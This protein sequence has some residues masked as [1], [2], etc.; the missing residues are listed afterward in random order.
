MSSL[1]KTIMKSRLPPMAPNSRFGK[2][3][4]MRKN[5]YTPVEW[6][7]YFEKFTDVRVE[8]GKFRIYM[9]GSEGPVLF[10]L[11]GGGLSALGWSLFA[12]CITKMVKCRV[13]AMD[14]R[15][16]GSTKTNDE[17]NLS[18]ETLSKDTGDVIQELYGDE[19]PPII[20][21]G[22]S[23]GGAIAIHTAYKNY[24]SNLI[25]LVV[26]DVVEG[27]AMDALSSM[28]SFLRGRPKTFVSLENAI[29]WCVRS[30]QV[31]NVESAKVS[32]P[33]QII[34]CETG[35]LAI[36]DISGYVP[37]PST[38]FVQSTVAPDQI[39]EENENGENSVNEK[40]KAPNSE[41]PKPKY[42]WRI[43]LSQTETHWPGWFKGLSSLFLSCSVPKL[44]ILAGIDTLDRELTVGQMQG[45]F[46]MQV[47]P[48]CGHAVHED[49]PDKVAE[50]LAS[51]M[52]VSWLLSG[53]ERIACERRDVR[54]K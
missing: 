21:M 38:P 43:D 44:L 22:H 48:Q 34:N 35:D 47:L 31:R 29:E 45:K 28:Q 2:R 33:G 3:M 26:I 39:L 15:G 25:G 7:K 10:L 24:I 8:S 32:M 51:F 36:E 17:F 9:L 49:V 46:Q 1:Q 42:K 54:V 37:T 19:S 4:A 16:H 11:H 5:D 30:G 27:T 52:T 18:A 23:M 53:V 40:F 20:L 50:V 41:A 12:E 6:N 13:V 14:L